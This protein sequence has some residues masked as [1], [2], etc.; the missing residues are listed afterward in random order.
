MSTTNCKVKKFVIDF[1]KKWIPADKLNKFL[2]IT[3]NSHW[4]LLNEL[5]LLEA[6]LVNAQDAG[7]KIDE[8]VL[9]EI[10]K[11]IDEINKEN[12]DLEDLTIRLK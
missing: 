1:I 4:A 12:L 11:V 9:K 6:S 5:D 10:A 8:E 2:P 7:D 3:N